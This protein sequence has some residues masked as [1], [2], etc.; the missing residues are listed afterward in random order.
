[1][2]AY[3]LASDQFLILDVARFKYPPVWV[4]A[5]RLWLAMN[6]IDRASGKTRGF[7]LVSRPAI[8]KP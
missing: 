1:V 2:A 8:T 3:D 7:V 6:T 4:K 5:E